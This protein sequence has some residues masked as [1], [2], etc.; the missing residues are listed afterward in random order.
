[1]K[2][3]EKPK[4]EEKRRE[5]KRRRMRQKIRIGKHNPRITR[6]QIPWVHLYRN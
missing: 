4:E 6:S 3:E 2:A 5:E 1:M